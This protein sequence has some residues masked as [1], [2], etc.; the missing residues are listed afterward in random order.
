[1]IEVTE[2]L[3]LEVGEV[4]EF[5]YRVT[6]PLPTKNPMLNLSPRG[7]RE[8]IILAAAH[9]DTPSVGYLCGS[10]DDRERGFCSLSIRLDSADDVLITVRGVAP[11]RY[12]LLGSLKRWYPTAEELIE[13]DDTECTTVT[14]VTVT[15]PRDAG[16]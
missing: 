7:P 14:S 15:A 13:N 4:G 11:G 3:E 1:M 12:V 5:E 2:S 6:G 16:E 10:N 8:G 9:P